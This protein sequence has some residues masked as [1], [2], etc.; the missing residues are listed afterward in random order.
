MHLTIIANPAKA[1]LDWSPFILEVL[2][3]P[4]KGGI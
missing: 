4:F 2:E 1:E 3:N